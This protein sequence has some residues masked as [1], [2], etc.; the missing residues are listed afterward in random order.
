MQITQEAI[1]GLTIQWG[2][3]AIVTILSFLMAQSTHRQ[4]LEYWTLGWACRMLSLTSLLIAFSLPVP[5]KILYT[6]YFAADYAFAYL[7]I[8]GC[9]NHARGA[10][11]SLHDCWVLVPTVILSLL[12]PFFEDRPGHLLIP[13]LPFAATMAG[14]WYAAFRVLRPRRHNEF[15]GTG[16][17]AI[18][19]GLIMLM[20]N[21]IHYVVIY[22][23][24]TVTQTTV[25]FAYLK[26]APLYDLLLEI[27]LAF[28]A[29]IFVLESLCRQLEGENHVLAAAG[30]HLQNLAEKDP[31]TGTLNRHA[32]YALLQK[33]Q[34]E[35]GSVALVDI[36]DFKLIN[37]D[38]GH[39]AGDVALRVVAQSIRSVIRA[40]DK[41]FRWG[42]DEFLILLH[43][44]VETEARERLTG[45][46]SILRQIPLSAGRAP[47][48]LVVSY[49]VAAFAGTTDL[50]R[51]IEQAD[52]EM[53]N[54]KQDRKA[55]QVRL[56]Q[57]TQLNPVG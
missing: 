50:E 34:N 25:A 27:L 3:I 41:L 39:A 18:R 46:N 26:Y 22:G 28:G 12:M 42:G 6:I 10:R 31:L 32:F 48:D 1:V 11:L 38:L 15:H 33:T 17:R 14:F 7:M 49:G 43:G 21:C 51:I 56:T 40:D 36:D 19:I 4:F 20:L 13:L 24:Q 23:Y 35:L 45:L 52:R 47:V 29:V 55:G 8:T 9:R 54:H 57:A 37:D 16:I 5:P 2:G 44:V 53:Y 30:A